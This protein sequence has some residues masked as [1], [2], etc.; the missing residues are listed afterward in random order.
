MFELSGQKVFGTKSTATNIH[1]HYVGAG[2][3]GWTDYRYSGRLM[4]DDPNGGI[5]VTLFS[6]YPNSDAY[7]RLRRYGNAPT[8]HIAPHPH[9]SGMSGGNLDTG[10][11]PQPNVWYRFLVE[12]ENTG[13]QTE[14]R[15]KVWEDGTAEP[16]DWQAEAYD[17]SPTRLTLG[18][19]GVWSYSYGS[20]YWDDLVVEP[21]TP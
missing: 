20:K 4:F 13:S 12:A 9:S 16:A 7:L 8:F 15:V 6:D 18:T 17:D 1:S 11:L 5:G 14:V 21:L 3:A 19:I 10:V 2:S